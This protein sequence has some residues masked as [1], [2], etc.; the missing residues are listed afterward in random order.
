[1]K[2]K[3]VVPLN[4][5]MADDLD[6]LETTKFVVKEWAKYYEGGYVYAVKTVDK[7]D[8]GKYEGHVI[9]Y[10]NTFG[11]EAEMEDEFYREFK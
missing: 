7:M 4:K 5:R 2:G 10:F 8:S 9:G 6:V 11:S 1:M 3:I